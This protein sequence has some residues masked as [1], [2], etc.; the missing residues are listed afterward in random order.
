MLLRLTR[1]AEQTDQ[2]TGEITF[3]TV[4]YLLNPMCIVDAES[5]SPVNVLWA[6]EYKAGARTLFTLN[7][8]SERGVEVVV[9]DDI[10]D[11]AIRC[12]AV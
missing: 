11:V 2:E 9:T 5:L 1:I 12:G 7:D 3:Y 6:S 4:P 8:G 10:T